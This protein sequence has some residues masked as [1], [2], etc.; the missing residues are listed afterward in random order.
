MPHCSK[1]VV[2]QLSN[3]VT[4]KDLHEE[5]RRPVYVF[6]L[7]TIQTHVLFLC[8]SPVTIPRDL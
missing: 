6:L 8:D 2:T 1:A 7:G 5:P 3:Y 4:F